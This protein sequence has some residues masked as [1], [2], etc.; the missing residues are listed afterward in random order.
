MTGTRYE[1]LLSRYK[2]QIS[3]EQPPSPAQPE[4]LDQALKRRATGFVYFA[5]NPLGWIKIGYSKHPHIRVG[6]LGRGVRLLALMPGSKEA[7]RAAHRL[8]EH[9]CII[10]EWFYLTE[11]LRSLIEETRARL[12]NAGTEA[13]LK[14]FYTDEE[15]A[16]HRAARDAEEERGL[17]SLQAAWDR[18]AQRDLEAT[19]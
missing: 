14:A 7:E 1:R 13:D 11:D 17:Q 15:T 5:Q 16:P 18:I 6:Q 10:G 19:L 3:K 4:T 2:L 12:G 9:C 8:F